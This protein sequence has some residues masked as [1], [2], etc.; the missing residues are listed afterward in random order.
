MN[1]N[2]IVKRDDVKNTKLLI[3]LLTSKK[4]AQLKIVN[5]IKNV[6]WCLLWW[7]EVIK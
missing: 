3:Y 5:D 7:E 6:G 1:I 4:A 2:D